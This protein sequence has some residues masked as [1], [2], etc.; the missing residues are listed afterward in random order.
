[1]DAED[2]KYSVELQGNPPKPGAPIP[3]YPRIAAVDAVD[4]YTVKLTMK[5]PDPT[6]LGWFAWSRW[7]AII[8]KDF[9]E[10]GKNPATTADGTGP[11]KLVEY[12]ANDRVAMQRFA[13]H[14]RSGSPNVDEI[15]PK[16]MPDESARVAALRSGA[17]DGTDV[18]GVRAEQPGDH[19]GKHKRRERQQNVPSGA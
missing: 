14:W 9:Y 8:P 17:I 11:Y 2:V 13:G 6:V 19:D 10:S 12:V 5:G 15:T 4:K 7:S 16:V 18:S 1:M 3:Q